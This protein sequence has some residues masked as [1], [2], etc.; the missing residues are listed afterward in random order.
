M[1]PRRPRPAFSLAPRLTVIALVALALASCAR[2][3]KPGGDW[4][5]VRERTPA[6]FASRPVFDPALAATA[7][8]RVALTYVTRDT[9]GADLWIVV[10]RDSGAHFSA[11][12]RL[13]ARHGKVSSYPE[14]R[15]VP[16]FGP[17]GLL[18]VAWASE[19]DTGRMADDIVARTSADDGA[20]FD[21]EIFLNDDRAHP[22]STYHG[23]V[24]LDVSPQ[25]RIVAAWID[26]RGETPVPGEEEP[27]I[28]QIS[29][30]F[31]DD[32]G[33]TWS[34]NMLVARSVCPCCRPTLRLSPT[35]L[36]AI[37]Y[38]GVR[39]SLRDPRMA[40]SRDGGATF[41]D[42]T[43]LWADGWKLDACPVAGPALSMAHGTGFVAWT[44]GA[45][46]CAGVWLAPWRMNAGAAGAR[47]PLVDPKLEPAHALLAPMGARTLAA[48]LARPESGRHA[49]G[50]CTLAP[51][52]TAS[53]WQW[54]GA[55]ARSAAIAGADAQHAFACWLEQGDGGPRL[56]LVELTRR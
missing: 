9:G 22:Q 38:R 54:L 56:R 1:T 39:D 6:E 40:F 52:G 25:G 35:G 11:P 30:T 28:A 31:S 41:E 14:S 3:P 55:A 42:D 18:V 48:V 43:L 34:P 47:H 24:T 7:D 23:F 50:V 53:R 51:D 36:A 5:S 15:A 2:A 29:S 32:G 27:R 20:N 8:G 13:N 46:T 12:V 37:A 26:A 21:P 17:R 49:L 45:D 10:S 44:T 33:R 19:R 16:V 4:A